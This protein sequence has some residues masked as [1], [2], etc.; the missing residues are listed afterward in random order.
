MEI[1]PAIDLRGGAVVRLFQGDYDRQTTF[2]DDPVLTAKRFEAGGAPRIHVVDLDGAKEGRRIQAAQVRAI[3]AAVGVPIQTGGGLRSSQDIEGALAD[4]ADRVVLGTAAV[5]QPE[6]VSGALA[7]HGADRIIAGIDAR[8][9]MAAVSGWTAGSDVA[10]AEL[11][12]RMAAVGVRR[13]VYTDIARDGT[14]TS[15]NLDAVAEMVERAAG[16]GDGVRIIAS[17]G[18]ADIDDLRALARLG[19]EGAIVGSAVYRG[20]LDLAA[21]VAEMGAAPLE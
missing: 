20:T 19:V 16:A 4:G 15:P 17:G 6:L 5:D 12:E 9:G 14:L 21:A 10:A 13:F 8:D 7:R 11:L 2:S 3:A 18:I 1:I